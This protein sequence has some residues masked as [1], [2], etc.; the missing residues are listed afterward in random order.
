[1]DTVGWISNWGWKKIYH[2]KSADIIVLTIISGRAEQSQLLRQYYSANKHR[3]YL[4]KLSKQ[5]MLN[6]EVN[7]HLFHEKEEAIHILG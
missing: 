7:K 4:I 3:T 6:I 2:E 1:M 5:D